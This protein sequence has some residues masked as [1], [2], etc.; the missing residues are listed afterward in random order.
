M[1]SPINEPIILAIIS[2]TSKNLPGKKE[3]CM[4]SM[5]IPYP[6]LIVKAIIIGQS[7]FLM[8]FA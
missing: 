5:S 3:Y 7:S 8:V 2:K 1:I 4:I 6:V